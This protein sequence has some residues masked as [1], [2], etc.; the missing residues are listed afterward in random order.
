MLIHHNEFLSFYPLIFLSHQKQRNMF[1]RSITIWVQCNSRVSHS[2]MRKNPICFWDVFSISKCPTKKI[3]V[4]SECLPRTHLLYFAFP[5]LIV[6]VRY[7]I[8]I[9]RTVICKGRVCYCFEMDLQKL[10]VNLEL[11]NSS[12]ANGAEVLLNCR[13]RGVSSILLYTVTPVKLYKSCLRK[14]FLLT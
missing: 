1:I 10:A 3:A 8:F 2:S 11:S 9:L 14:V 5:I 12:R 13:Q 7:N 6:Y 4:Q